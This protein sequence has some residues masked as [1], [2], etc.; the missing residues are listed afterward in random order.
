MSE[1]QGATAP[2]ENHLEMPPTVGLDPTEQAE[3]QTEEAAT[4]DEHEEGDEPSGK[5]PRGVQKRINELTKERYEERRRADRLEQMLE[6][7]IP[8]LQQPE[9]PPA[10]RDPLAK[11]DPNEFPAGRYDP[12]YLEALTDYKVA[13]R[14]DQQTKAQQQAQ[15]QR[16]FA[17][18]QKTLT[19]KEAEYAAQHK[20]YAESRVFVLQ[21]PEI[22]NHPGIGYAVTQSDNPAALIH[23]LGSHADEALQIA[24]LEPMAAAMRI[25]RIE[26]ELSAKPARQRASSNAPDPIKPVGTGGAV[27]GASAKARTMEEYAALRAKELKRA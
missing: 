12:D 16:E 8:R 22:A 17:E 19:Q 27:V 13:I 11:P 4:P 10:Q 1:E 21:T 20:D 25:S 2:V 26:A 9:P 24:A 6:S 18:R 15:A 5:P 23:Y 7:I 3:Q 14:L